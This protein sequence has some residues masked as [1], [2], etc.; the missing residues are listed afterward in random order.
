MADAAHDPNSK[1]TEPEKKQ[2][3]TVL[4]TAEELRTIAGGAGPGTGPNP[5]AK[6]VTA[7][8]SHSPLGPKA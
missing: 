2:P 4:L 8:G 7:G 5:T 3:E 6:D 1:T